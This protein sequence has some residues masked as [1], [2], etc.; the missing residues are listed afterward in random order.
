MKCLNTNISIGSYDMMGVDGQIMFKV[1]IKLDDHV[2]SL[3][4]Q[5]IVPIVSRELRRSI[6]L[7]LSDELI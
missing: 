6:F 3:S 4:T 7:H 5:Q 1:H 2:Y